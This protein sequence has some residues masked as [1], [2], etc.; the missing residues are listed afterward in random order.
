MPMTS[1]LEPCRE[2]VDAPWVYGEDFESRRNFTCH[3]ETGHTGDHHADA[4]DEIFTWDDRDAA[5][6]AAEANA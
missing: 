1:S 3:R 2:S 4:G 6:W 5:L